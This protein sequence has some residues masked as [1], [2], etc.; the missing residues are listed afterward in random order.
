MLTVQRYVVQSTSGRVLV[1]FIAEYFSEDE[2]VYTWPCALAM[3]SYLL[4]YSNVV[5]GKVVLEL[6][7][8]TGLSSIISL[9]LGAQ[10]VI[11]TERSAHEFLVGYRL[12]R[13]NFELNQFPTDQY[14]VVCTIIYNINY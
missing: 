8:G 7:S 14:T 12:L 2:T 3:A 11:S 9:M 1:P 13:Y 5:E 10:H 6:G 4:A